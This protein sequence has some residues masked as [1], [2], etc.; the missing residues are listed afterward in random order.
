MQVIKI[1][2]LNK[3]VS[4]VDIDDT[5]ESIYEQL[6]CEIF[7]CPITLDN[8]DCLYVDD[9]GLLVPEY[10]G[11]FYFGDYPQPYFGNGLII[12]TSVE[13]DNQ[14]VLSSIKSIEN[15]VKFLPEH[16]GEYLLEQMKNTGFTF[17]PM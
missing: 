16:T 8:K 14:D 15:K 9:E 2:P 12:G 17:I 10:K 1:D 5:L 7:T 13:G 11:A 4:Y 3:T 6:E